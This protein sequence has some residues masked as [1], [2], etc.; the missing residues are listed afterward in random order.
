VSITFRLAHSHTRRE[1]WIFRWNFW[2]SRQRYYLDDLRAASLQ[3]RNDE[4]GTAIL[5]TFYQAAGSLSGWMIWAA[6]EAAGDGGERGDRGVGEDR[7]HD[8][9][10][11]A[12]WVSLAWH[13]DRLTA[14]DIKAR[15]KPVDR[16]RLL[17]S[18]KRRRR[19]RC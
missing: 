4:G 17:F 10:A 18:R 12:F 11:S 7:L 15:L 6:L 9:V 5:E 3:L 13:S 8:R 14:D 19:T 1:R 16:L 2:I